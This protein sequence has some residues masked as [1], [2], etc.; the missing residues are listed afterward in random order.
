MWMA[1]VVRVG[2][3][4]SDAGVENCDTNSHGPCQVATKEIEEEDG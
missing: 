4:R 1:I 3:K 2:R